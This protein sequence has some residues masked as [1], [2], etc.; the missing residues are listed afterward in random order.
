MNKANGRNIIVT[1]TDPLYELDPFIDE[2]EIL[3][4]RWM[5]QENFLAK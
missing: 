2:N 3:K 5:D 1:K 4:S